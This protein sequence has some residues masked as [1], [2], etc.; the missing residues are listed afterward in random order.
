MMKKLLILDGNS[1]VHRAFHALPLLSTTTGQFTN[2]VYGFT[3]MLQKLARDEKPDYLAVAFDRSKATFRHQEYKHYKANRK[4]TPDELRPQFPLVKKVLRAL[5]I[6]ILELDG[7]EGD[8]LIGAVAKA[9]EEKGFDVVIVTG[10]RDLL[11]LV[12]EH[13][14]A[15]ITRRGISDLECFTPDDVKKKYGVEPVQ[16]PDLKGLKGDQSDNIP[17]VPG[18]GQKTAVKLLT[19]FGSVEECIA[20]LDQL[21]TRAANSLQEHTE[22]ALLSKKL[23]TLAVDVPLEID[24]SDFKVEQPDYEALIAIYQELE[25]KSLLKNLQEELPESVVDSFCPAESECRI[26]STVSELVSLFVE[27]K[28]VGEFALCFDRDGDSVS[29]HHAPLTRLGLA[30]GEESYAAVIFSAQPELREKMLAAMSELFSASECKKLCHDAK[31][32]IIMCRRHG[33]ELQGVIGDTMLAAY[34]LNSSTADPEL[35]EITLK[36]CNQVVAF[37]EDEQGAAQRALA[38]WQLWPVLRDALED[39]EL[40]KLFY[41]LELPLSGIL[42]QME[43]TG[44]KLDIEQLEEMSSELEKQLLTL[45]EE[46]YTLAGEK[47]NINSPKQLGHIL[48]EKLKLPVIKRTKTGYSTNAEVLEKLVP[49]HDIAEHVLA[50]R[51]LTK[52]K[53]TY[54]DGLQGLVNKESDK[55]H[56]TFNQ[57]ITA[58]GRLSSAEPN[59]QNI[60]IKM[61]LGRKIRK[62]FVPSEPGWLILAADYSQIELRVL[63]HMSGDERLIADFLHGE[64]IHTRTA[65]TIF[66]VEQEEVTPDL[67]RRAKG[68]NYGIVYGITEYGL[69]RDVGVSRDEAALYIANYFRNYAG[70][71][72]FIDET[73]AAARE[74]GYVETLLKRRRYL[75]DLLSS[76]RN[77]R[78][79]GERTAVNTPIQGS[80]ADIIKLAMLHIDRE[81]QEKG[82]RARMLLQVHDEL[83]FELPPEEVGVLIPLVRTGM[84]NVIKLVVPLEVDIEIGPNW[85]NLEKAEEY[86]A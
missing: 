3:N 78:S 85:Y 58:T 54:I 36:Y 28:E 18:I 34:L 39:D 67:R 55:V 82:L 63:A 15:F 16:V 75:P 86:H 79:F 56:T 80:A 77:V 35:E 43:L 62:S 69:A 10:D 7:F 53:S 11:Q 46:I 24:F 40:D 52:L 73:I 32:E 68:V 59:L 64:D 66:G 51:Q 48:F 33:L 17:G 26:V 9:A 20:N 61:D 38:I 5:R 2:A 31:A 37:D 50:Y 70:V 74:K 41:E 21:P 47:F 29:P 4:A 83:V 42:A 49:H 81:L 14:R 44:I 76:N 65:A 19:Q 71:K 84:E 12:S 57:T 25:F 45:T 1:L 72:R 27:L 22:E 13:T 8:D 23:A 30:W 60:P 6:P